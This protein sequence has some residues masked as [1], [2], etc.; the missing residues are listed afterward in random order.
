MVIFITTL[1]ICCLSFGLNEGI[2]KAF[3][4]SEQPTGNGTAAS[5]YLISTAGNLQWLS[6]NIST[7][8]DKNFKQINDIDCSG[9]TFD[10]I[11]TE[12]DMFSGIYDG[13]GRS[14]SNLNITTP[15]RTAGLLGNVS[16][17]NT[18]A[19][20]VIKNLTLKNSAILCT[21]P[22]SVCSVGGIAGWSSGTIQNCSVVNTTV[23][24]QSDTSSVGGIAG[25]NQGTIKDCYST[26][27]LQG[28]SG[29]SVGGIA[30]SASNATIQNC[31][32]AGSF[33]GASTQKGGIVSN[34]YNATVSGNY[35]L[36][37]AATYGIASPSGNTG[38]EPKTSAALQQAGTYS[39][40]DFNEVW[41][42]GAESYPQ[43]RMPPTPSGSIDSDIV[44]KT[45]IVT[46]CAVDDV[47]KIY[48]AATGGT[49]LGSGTVAAGQTS[50]TISIPT[51]PSLHEVFVSTATASMP[52]SGRTQH[53]VFSVPFSEGF[54][55]A[56]YF[57]D[58]W[59][60]E[61]VIGGSTPLKWF[62][63]ETETQSQT[64]Y[65]LDLT[66]NPYSGSYMMK[67]DIWNANRPLSTRLFS[68]SFGLPAGSY[69]LSFYLYQH[70]DV[71]NDGGTILGANDYIQTQISFNG[72]AW[73]DLGPQ[74]KRVDGT[75]WV[76]HTVTFTC[77]TGDT[78]R[79]GLLGYSDWGYNL[80]VD[81]LSIVQNS[82]PQICTVTYDPEGGT[83]TPA[84]QT[85]LFQSAYGKAADGM[86]SEPMPTPGK[87]GYVFDG[88]YNGD[89]GTGDQITDTTAVDT[90]SNHT[91]YAKWI[92][93]LTA[94]TTD[95][96]VDND[97]EITFG[98]DAA[99]EGAITGVSFGGTALTVTT[100]Y[101]VSSGKVTLKPSGGNAVLQTPAT[102][103][104]VITAP[105][106]NSSTVS[107]TINH[108]AAI[109]MVVTQNITAPDSN[110]GQFA[111]Q[112][113]VTLK[114]TYG[115]TCTNDNTTVVTASKVDTG[116]W[117]LTGTVTVTASA[118]VATFTNLGATNASAVTDAQLA[119]D[120]TGLTRITSA[121][122]NLP[123]TSTPT[124][125]ITTVSLPNGTVGALY[126][127]TL[128]ASGGTAPYTWSATGL[129]LGLILDTVS[130][131]VYGN[132]VSAG[133][134][135]VSATVYDY[136]G[137]SDSA[138]FTLTVNPA[139]GLT[140]ST[141]SLPGGR[142]GISYSATLIATGGTEPYTWTATGLPAG[143][144]INQASGL[145]SGI[146]TSVGT[147][148][149]SATVYDSGGQS[150]GESFIL[151]IT[152]KS[153]GKG[154]STS[155]TQQPTSPSSNVEI[156]VNGKVEA[157]MATASTT[158]VGDR[159]V[160]TVVLDPE[161]LEEKLKQEGENSVVTIPVSTD[162]DTVIG[163]LT[164][165]MVKSMEQKSAVV[166]IKTENASYTLPA[167]QINIDDVSAQLGQNVELK[168]INVNIEIA[169]STD[170]TVQF[171]EDAAEKNNYTIVVPP[172]DFKVTC[173]YGNKTV[174]VTH[175]NAFVERTIAIP[176]GIDPQRITTAVIVNSDG[177][178]THV[179]TQII[180][181]DG[182]YYAVVNS[183]TNS[184]YMV[185]W[186]LKAFKD[187][188]SHWA[189]DYVNEMGSRLVVSG[190]DENNYS[191]DREVTRAEFAAIIVRAL[192]L[193]EKGN[194]NNF[195]DV[196]D[197]D[198][199]NGA[200]STA[201]AYGIINGYNDGTF[202]PNKA[203]SREEAMV[204]IAGAAKLA[205]IDADSAGPDVDAQLA[206]FKDNESIDSW[207][208]NSAAACVKSGIMVGDDSMLT[209]D[210]DI[211]RA[212][213]ATIVMRMLQKA[214]LI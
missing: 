152:R 79:I 172:V 201:Y 116:D 198:W 133:N 40:W 97:I 197:S 104:V 76:Q 192:G 176:E 59:E 64:G 35:F 49:L 23:E 99:F 180:V 149:V 16:N 165:Q 83:V 123:A 10:P 185:I 57:Q 55:N 106:Y 98:A 179:P 100:D 128:T 160:T 81:D 162:A 169:R 65:D 103:D 21:D 9:V 161:K 110:G 15:L 141:S 126:S 26:A 73:V 175:F 190:V 28:V 167:A 204:I 189:K 60:T 38:A 213:A 142:V 146:P 93:I 72:G 87:A 131:Q 174:E 115:N 20:G 177:T 164:G 43:L 32:F 121:K 63:V 168:D 120:T 17:F 27:T 154:P 137:S 44:S 45:V 134:S 111:Q 41:Y 193:G 102:A 58:D 127:A 112:P 184:T 209:P 130:G 186:H 92:K 166:E 109:T 39:G 86:T 140:I 207:A 30:G 62:R 95:N 69:D 8:R 205:G 14:I 84:T 36:D 200:V 136:Y 3:A 22:S 191:P 145:I 129:P 155:P 46:G 182:K 11:G 70:P 125:A 210:H 51:L 94:D 188:E 56:G 148:T 208:R 61:E 37:T 147:S 101:V 53:R 7:V 135:T 5:P 48:D 1:M 85:K 206:K 117:I 138:S 2:D 78:V 139:S 82:T 173:T 25:N 181:R 96:N 47:I 114:D 66:I 71:Y 68:R 195:K 157:G 74:I 29:A 203:I 122:V 107:Q 19:P 113:Q 124:L 33:A 105:G 13:S 163:Q 196:S 77:S 187:V 50:I 211:T 34:T 91:L 194:K 199:F 144:T 170:E 212:E 151:T 159:A 132:P 214:D 80:Y 67:E 42:L 52:E 12:A 118:G 150:T 108:G 119:F 153:S 54:E 4:A 90:T 88:W 156:M 24:A 89:N 143:L 75:G 158:T 178:F 18:D 202:N 171:V 183:L 6:E 31:Y